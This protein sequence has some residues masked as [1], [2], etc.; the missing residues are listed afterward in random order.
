LARL[1]RLRERD[2]QEP[3]LTPRTWGCREGAQVEPPAADAELD[4][5]H[6]ARVEAQRVDP[7]VLHVVEG[8]RR[9]KAVG[10]E[11]QGDVRQGTRAGVGEA[12]AHPPFDAPLE[13]I[14]GRADLVG[15]GTRRLCERR[16]AQDHQRQE[17]PQAARSST[18]HAR[19]ETTRNRKQKT[20]NRKQKTEN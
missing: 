10:G 11:P 7:V 18:G 3:L 12:N 4:E 1:K 19:L 14:D 9:T 15:T 17:L 8:W 5:L 20:E 2:A 13:G 16:R 6:G